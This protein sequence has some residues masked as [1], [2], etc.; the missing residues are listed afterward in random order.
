MRHFLKYFG[1]GKTYDGVGRPIPFERI[2]PTMEA[3]STDDPDVIKTLDGFIKDRAGGVTET[4]EQG[5]SD[6]KKKA[7]DSPTPRGDFIGGP[8]IAQDTVTR[9][10]PVAGAAGVGSSM[11]PVSD[12]I[13]QLKADMA[14]LKAK[15]DAPKIEK[16]VPPPTPPSV[17][18]RG[19][20]KH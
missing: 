16:D 10:V 4:T 8:M 2:A 14:A 3:I 11:L 13:A 9:S 20:A 15:A 5:I 1:G 12:E 6:L 19:T 18:K 7:T 17:G